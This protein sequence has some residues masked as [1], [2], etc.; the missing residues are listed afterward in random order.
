MHYAALYLYSK[1]FFREGGAWDSPP[2]PAFIGF[3]L[4]KKFKGFMTTQANYQRQ[5]IS[6]KKPTGIFTY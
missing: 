1:A 5:I 2:P 4:I 3:N 6:L